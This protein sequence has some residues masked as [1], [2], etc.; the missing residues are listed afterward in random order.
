MSREYELK[1]T[2]SILEALTCN[3]NTGGDYPSIDSLS[4]LIE[5]NLNTCIEKVEYSKNKLNELE[6]LYILKRKAELSLKNKKYKKAYKLLAK[7][8]TIEGIKGSRRSK[9]IIYKLVDECRSWG[10][11]DEVKIESTK[12]EDL[13]DRYISGIALYNIS[14][15][16]PNPTIQIYKNGYL[17]GKYCGCSYLK[18]DVIRNV[19]KLKEEVIRKRKHNFF[20]I[21]TIPM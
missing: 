4:R 10:C 18:E 20:Y 19:G 2:M 17:I 12:L 7:I 15:D 8:N 3:K 6:Y 13:L 9:K 5:D 14:F 1:D 11:Y 21:D 16:L